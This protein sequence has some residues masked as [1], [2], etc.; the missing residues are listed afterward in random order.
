[1]KDW[2]TFLV[3]NSKDGKTLNE[4][5]RDY[6]LYTLQNEVPNLPDYGFLLQFYN[7]IKGGGDLN[8]IILPYSGYILTEGGLNILQENGSKIFL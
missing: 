1:M 6:Y 3:D 7:Y 2:K 5:T 4:I 8:N